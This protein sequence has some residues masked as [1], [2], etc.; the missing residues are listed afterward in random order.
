MK[1]THRFAV[2]AAL[3]AA[4]A[5]LAPVQAAPAARGAKRALA[6]HAKPSENLWH[7]RA[8]LNVA[9]LSCRGSG[10]ERVAPAYA[11]LLSRHRS[12]LASSYS[13][14]Q[15]KHGGKM[16][17]HLTQL[18]NR[19]SYQRSPETF[20]TQAAAVADRAVAMDSPTLARHAG[21]LLS[22]ID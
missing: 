3:I 20:C 9:A 11:R 8:G 16:D 13:L 17:R 12:L 21:S 10:R 2:A 5:G 19:F 15:Q 6:L 14:E 18:Y 22:E 1:S 7:L 4:I